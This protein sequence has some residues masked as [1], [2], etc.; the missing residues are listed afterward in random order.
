MSRH[1]W[2]YGGKVK[3]D[4]IER[5]SLSFNVTDKLKLVAD[6]G[7]PQLRRRMFFVGFKNLTVNLNSLKQL[8][9]KTICNL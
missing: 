2:T 3:E 5:F 6:Y 9:E 1:W 8:M 4:I 7:V